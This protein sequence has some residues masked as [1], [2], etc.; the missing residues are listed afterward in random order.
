MSPK[1]LSGHKQCGR[2]AVLTSGLWFQTDKEGERRSPWKE[3][4]RAT[5]FNLLV[6]SCPDQE[7][8]VRR[9]SDLLRPERNRNREASQ[10]LCLAPC[11]LCN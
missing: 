2:V 1:C 6:V 4:S 9:I 3:W 5:L 10:E 7:E 8:R 11:R